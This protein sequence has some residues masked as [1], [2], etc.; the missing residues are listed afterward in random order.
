MISANEVLRTTLMPEFVT[1]DRWLWVIDEKLVAALFADQSASLDA[2]HPLLPKPELR[3][4]QPPPP[5]QLIATQEDLETPRLWAAA[6]AQFESRQDEAALETYRALLAKNPGNPDITYNIA[7]CLRQLG[8]YNEATLAFETVIRLNPELDAARVGLAWCLLHLRRAERALAMFDQQMEETPG[9]SCAARGRAQALELLRQPEAAALAYRA[10]LMEDPDNPDI[11]ANLIAVS[12]Q[13][14][15]A[16][17]LRRYSADLLHLR[18]RS[19]QALAGLVSADLA[20]GDYEAGIRHASEFVRI[21]PKSYEAWFNLGLASQLSNR[22]DEAEKAYREASGLDGARIDPLLNLGSVLMERGRIAEAQACFDRA[23]AQDP[24]N[25]DALWNLA[26]LAERQG[27]LAR[28]ETYTQ[29]L[30]DGHAEKIEALFHLGYLRFLQ[31]N[32]AGSIETFQACLGQRRDWL[33]A[34]V[35]LALA[36]QNSGNPASA[37][38]QLDQALQ[39]D[40]IFVPALECRLA[41]ALAAHDFTVAPELEAQLADLGHSSP[42]FCYNLGILQVEANQLDAASQSYRRA[43]GKRPAFAEALINLG[44][45]LKTLGKHDEAI[46]IWQNAVSAR[47]DLAHEYFQG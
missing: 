24:Q 35:Y 30:L 8:R 2:P 41:L 11:L 23:L 13:R 34:R 15:D 47:P 25:S 16:A 3:A 26:L 33:D 43:V 5:A 28:A 1:A 4:P 14:E 20:T 42:E 7:L 6:T 31:R 37:V 22:L 39:H 45:T 9:D 19:R 12:A 17:E 10:L 27:D 18:P 29:R 44:H 36:F 38:A 21:E 32:W 46:E 40:P